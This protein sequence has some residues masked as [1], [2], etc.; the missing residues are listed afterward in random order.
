M[1]DPARWVMDTVHLGTKQ[2]K[3]TYDAAD[4]A[5]VMTPTW[6]PSDRDS[7]DVGV[8]NIENG[9][10]QLY[11]LVDA[12]DCSQAVS[13]FE[14]SMPQE[15]IDEGKLEL[16]FALQAGAKGDYLF[17]GR[18]FTMA[19]FAGNGGQYKKLIV[20]APDYH[21]PLEKLRAIERVSFIFERKGSTISAPIKIRHVAIDLNTEKIT[22]PA[23]VVRVKNPKSFYEFT[24]TTQ[25]NVDGLT[26]RV[27]A[28]SMD[29]TRRVNDAK[30]G[31]ALI[32][33]WK[34]GQ[35]PAGHSGSVTLVQPLGAIN[36]F[37]R[38]EAQYVLNIPK[39]Y[40]DEGKLDLWIFIQAGETGYHRWSGTPRPLTAFAE[41]A[42]QDVVLTVTQEDFLQGKQRNQ[43]E[44][45]GLQLNRNG[46]T[47]TEPIMLK[48]ITVKLP[49]DDQ[50]QK[51]T[52]AAVRA[53]GE[54]LVN[55]N[56]AAGMTNW[57]VEESG[58]T[59]KAE[60]VAEG[61]GGKPAMR[62]K[63]LTVGDQ[64]WKLQVYQTGM[65]VEQGRE[66]VLKLW[67]KSDRAGAITVNCQQNHEPWEHHT[68]EKLPVNSEWQE[69]RFAFVAPW[70]DDKIRISFTDLGTAPG[71][72][73]WFVNCS[74][75]PHA[76]A[77]SPVAPAPAAVGPAI[78]T[79]AAFVWKGDC[80][81]EAAFVNSNH[82]RIPGHYEYLPDPNEPR[83]GI[84]FAGHL[85][86]EFTTTD[87]EK[88]HLHPEIYFDR[89]IPGNLITASFDVKVDD[90]APSELGPY[91]GDPWL[92]LVTLFDET[93]FAGGKNFHPAL[94][95]NLVGT[96][97]HHRLQA[98]SID[99]AGAGTFYEK[100]EGG[101]V[102]PTG[103]WVTV[104]VEVDAK[105][106]RALVYQD[107]TLAS[108]GPYLGKPGLAG[109]HMGLYANRKMTRA[110]VFNDDITITVGK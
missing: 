29:I 56:F 28:E 74:L 35:I 8:R 94:M 48:R 27:S 4:Q 77:A 16:V 11:Q 45:V 106:K 22:P 37:E 5:A 70:T 71:Q 103:K 66:Y 100:I 108:T 24:Y 104:R 21:E 36:D 109:A 40:F 60:V 58:A 88:F 91:G 46:S 69:L 67:A 93:I 75:M 55:G 107:Q 3:I 31:V 25:A 83:R 62:L 52:R 101:P 50:P 92:N 32:P 15:Y 19:D 81:S 34:A 90:L 96:A 102:F 13:G 97:A 65:R 79:G 64:P 23:E 14:I 49:E 80:S 76:E 6:S 61:P 78:S 86:P 47:V 18:T 110:T 63:V 72:V 85:T 7:D 30:D 42:G 54:M 43:I 20:S 87:P 68:Q 82:E 41:K 59:G 84:V 17:N 2:V 33:Q 105:T 51:A 12:K 10:L 89:F 73:Y 9:R 39:A 53:S 98:Y 26:A 38:F 57:V 95:V 44:M 1:S 99:A